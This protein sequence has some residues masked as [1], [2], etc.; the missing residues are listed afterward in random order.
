MLETRVLRSRN[1]QKSLNEI[2]IDFS[3]LRC[4]GHI[5]N[6]V[7]KALLPKG[8]SKVERELAGA[9]SEEAFKIWNK[10]GPIGKL[11]N[12]CVYVNTNSTRQ[13][14]FKGCQGGEFQ[15]YRL[16]VDGGIRWN[17]TEAMISRGMFPF[18]VFI[19]LADVAIILITL[20]ILAIKRHAAIE[21]IN[22]G[23]NFQIRRIPTIFDN[24]S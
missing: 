21:F 18:I 24:T 20:E 7:V 19:L 11:H 1:W 16:L 6:L 14:V 5:I 2:D 12:I 22:F 8:V 9:S 17:S 15:V 3:R 10:Q 13:T 23:G 4:L